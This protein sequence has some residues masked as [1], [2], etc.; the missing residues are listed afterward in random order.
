MC[1]SLESLI[2]G[3]E[4]LGVVASRHAA[5]DSWIFVALHDD[6]LGVP[7]GGCR[8][9]RYDSPAAGL[10]DAM[11]L[12]EGM[13]W[14]WAAMRLRYGG[15]KSVLAVPGPV[16]GE[17]R[18][19]LFTRFGEV[20]NGLNGAY[21]VGEDMGT[22]PDDMA[23]LATVT[24]HVAGAERGG[25]PADPGPF[26]A[27]GVHA[28]MLAAVEHLDG[29]RD[30]S[31]RTVLV[32]GVGDVGEPLARLLGE[33]GA[34]VLVC[35]LD[36]GRAQG[37][38]AAC[39]GE[40][41][42]PATVYDTPCDI[43]APCAVGATLNE[44]TI[45]RLRCRI[46]AGSANN[47]L[48]VEGDAERIRARGILYA[49]DYVINGGGAMAFGLTE[50]GVRGTDELIARVRTIGDT[51]AEIFRDAEARGTSSVASARAMAAKALGRT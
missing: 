9:A 41:V 3:W 46:V 27:A 26:T 25:R 45:P 10:R 18:R 51:L 1:A 35:D 14:K 30:L 21:R 6:T 48:E 13:T 29:T 4:G 40:A 5:T 38:A 2:E 31:G 37:V 24:P 36:A 50:D 32:Q 11:R 23:F 15:G 19:A 8:M 49:P 20:L 17:A 7:T 43:Y 34:H 28:G 39:G 33:S 47:Q 22:T 12:A 42:D 44:R 16:E